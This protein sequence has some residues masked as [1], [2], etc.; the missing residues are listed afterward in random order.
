MF[1]HFCLCKW[2][3]QHEIWGYL[4]ARCS[5][6][7]SHDFVWCDTVYGLCRTEAKLVYGESV[8]MFDL[9]SSPNLPP[10]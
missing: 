9:P 10:G 3:Q 5:L 1:L 8:Y 4:C 7:Y 6:V 2:E